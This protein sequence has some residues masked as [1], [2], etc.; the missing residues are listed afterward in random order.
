LLQFLTRTLGDNSAAHIDE[1]PD[2]QIIIPSSILAIRY[3]DEVEL[4]TGPDLCEA[5]GWQVAHTESET[6]AAVR[7]R[8]ISA[9]KSYRLRTLVRLPLH[10]EYAID[11]LGKTDSD[12]RMPCATT[13]CNEE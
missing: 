12:F 10:N 11:V 1:L 4:L 2:Y 3:A 13:N 6:S 8:F 5:I 9:A 7:A